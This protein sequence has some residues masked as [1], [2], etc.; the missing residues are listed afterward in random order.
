MTQGQNCVR[1][2]LKPIPS[3]DFK[4]QLINRII[5]KIVVAE[6]T[7]DIQPLLITYFTENGSFF[8]Y[9]IYLF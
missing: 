9:G 8:I 3:F 4:N 2:L 5:P 1:I 6:R 7:Y